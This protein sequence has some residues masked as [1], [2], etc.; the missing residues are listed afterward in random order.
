MS[1]TRYPIPRAAERNKA[2]LA[3]AQ[4]DAYALELRDHGLAEAFA[5]RDDGSRYQM[6]ASAGGY[7]DASRD[8]LLVNFSC[9]CKAGAGTYGV[10]PCKHTALLARALFERGAIA[11]DTDGAYIITEVG[12]GAAS[13]YTLAELLLPYATA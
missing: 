10:T 4:A 13:T 5:V 9:Q 6:W 12:L 7:I 3:R 2:A 1:P 11:I 8:A